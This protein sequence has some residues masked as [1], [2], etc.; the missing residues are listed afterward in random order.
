MSWNILSTGSDDW[1]QLVANAPTG[2]PAGP[3]FTFLSSEVFSNNSDAENLD[4]RV[5]IEDLSISAAPSGATKQ[6]LLFV[7]V[8]EEVEP[9]VY[10]TIADSTAQIINKFV[11]D[12][13]TER[14]FVIQKQN[15]AD[16]GQPF[17]FL[18]GFRFNVNKSPS[19][20]IRVCLAVQDPQAGGEAA[21]DTI[22][23]SGS[24]RLY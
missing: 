22:T 3:T 12:F 16:S 1:N 17:S 10:R 19:E 18:G 23:V 5:T 6:F 9:G 24:Y 7:V 4:V 2:V 20:K 15:P 14:E 21:L 8:E 13:P 11:N